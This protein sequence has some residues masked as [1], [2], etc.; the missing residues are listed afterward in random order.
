VLLDRGNETEWQY[1]EFRHPALTVKDLR[2]AA[3]VISGL[4]SREVA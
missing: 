3:S 2:E 1:N 4:R